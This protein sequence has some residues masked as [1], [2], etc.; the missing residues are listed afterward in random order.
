MCETESQ[1]EIER[2]AMTACVPA[3]CLNC[4]EHIRDDT[5]V[6]VCLDITDSLS[7]ASRADTKFIMDFA[8]ALFRG[9]NICSLSIRVLIAEF[10]RV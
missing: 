10:V 2:T 6:R 3:S 1:L 7:G 8:S 5:S 4:A 9:V